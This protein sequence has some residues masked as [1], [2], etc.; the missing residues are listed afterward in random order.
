MNNNPN[1]AE[2]ISGLKDRNHIHHPVYSDKKKPHSAF[3]SARFRSAGTLILGYLLADKW[4]FFD[5]RQ[6]IPRLVIEPIAA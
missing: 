4:R 3:A 1:S 6:Q 2:T 5:I